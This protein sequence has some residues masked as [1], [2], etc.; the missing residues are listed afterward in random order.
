MPKRF[1]NFIRQ[2][3]SSLKNFLRGQSECDNRSEGDRS[4]LCSEDS[5]QSYRKRSY[6]YDCA[7]PRMNR[8]TLLSSNISESPVILD[9]RLSN[10]QE[11]SKRTCIHSDAEECCDNIRRCWSEDE[12][13][14]KPKKK[15]SLKRFLCVIP[16]VDRD[17]KKHSYK[18]SKSFKDNVSTEATED[19][20]ESFKTGENLSVREESTVEEQNAKPEQT[21]ARPK[22]TF[23]EPATSSGISS[24]SFCLEDSNEGPL[25]EK[26]FESAHSETAKGHSSSS[27]CP[28]FY[29]LLSCICMF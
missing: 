22:T 25:M 16:E 9:K 20:Y 13:N 8:T 21:G 27:K 14:K 28:L 15:S 18:S 1:Q 10:N 7:D 26:F 5:V 19:T 24:L 11:T 2:K 4:S 3:A 12:I 23:K 6:S 29:V 17:E